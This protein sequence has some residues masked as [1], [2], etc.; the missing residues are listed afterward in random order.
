MY[1]YNRKNYKK[2]MSHYRKRVQYD[3]QSAPL[4]HSKNKP[5]T[6]NTKNNNMDKKPKYPF[7]DN[8]SAHGNK[9]TISKSKIINKTPTI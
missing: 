9:Y 1:K 7:I 2:K 6:N 5:Q 3:Q 8:V 4:Y